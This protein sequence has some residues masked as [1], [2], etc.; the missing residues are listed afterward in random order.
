M[1]EG[2]RPGLK[3]ELAEIILEVAEVD[4]DEFPWSNEG[5]WLFDSA[6]DIDDLWVMEA[7]AERLIAAAKE[8][9]YEIR[10]RM[11]T[12]VA[13][14][15]AVRLGDTLYRVGKKGSREII[16][17]QEQPLLDWV[18]DDL[19]TSVPATAVRIT[20]VRAIAERRGLDAEVVEDT[21]YFW[22]SDPS[23]PYSLIRVYETKAPKYFAAMTHGDRR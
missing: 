17:G 2:D 9:L 22:D 11:A 16:V 23:E 6:E 15:G 20:A 8:V 18:G 21:F 14:F 7:A 13:E 5:V 19:R 12:D 10:R 1:G 3:R 4:H